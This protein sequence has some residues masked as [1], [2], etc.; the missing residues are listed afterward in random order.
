[1]TLMAWLAHW[2]V[3]THSGKIVQR[4]GKDRSKEK[5]GSLQ[6]FW[7]HYATTTFF[8][9]LPM[10]MLVARMINILNLSP[11]LERLVDGQMD[12]AGAS[13][14]EIAGKKFIVLVD[15]I[16]PQYLRFVQGI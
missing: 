12:A 2:I 8:G 15:G 14:F 4:H 3:C 11:F 1:M 9:M 5:K 10:V 13:P 16:Y 7:R 6:W